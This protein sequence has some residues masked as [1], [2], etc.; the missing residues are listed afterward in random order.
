MKSVRNR[1]QIRKQTRK[2]TRKQSH[3]KNCKQSRK[4]SRKQTKKR[5]YKRGGKRQS[6]KIRK[7]RTMFGGEIPQGLIDAGYDVVEINSLADFNSNNDIII[8]NR[9]D[10]TRVVYIKA[11]D[12]DPV[13][14]L[15]SQ[16]EGN[17]VFGP[18][19]FPRGDES[20]ND[21]D[22]SDYDNSDYDDVNSQIS[23]GG[24]PNL[25]GEY[26]LYSANNYN[27]IATLAYDG[28]DNDGPG[29]FVFILVPEDDEDEDQ[30]DEDEDQ[31][32]NDNG[33]Y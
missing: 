13:L 21:S 31:H 27:P 16:D 15:S 29:F 9:D 17:F 8:F 7:R 10:G 20:N 30:H 24:E 2:Q 25:H 19:N 3:K 4:Q 22:N 28:Y 1:K 23:E 6:K 12:Y 11:K 26:S 32:Y 33:D 5:A 18:W 14:S